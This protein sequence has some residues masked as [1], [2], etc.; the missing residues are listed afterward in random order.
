MK[1]FNFLRA[2]KQV[3]DGRTLT[4]EDMCWALHSAQTDTLLSM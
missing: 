1:M 3:P 4:H 2:I